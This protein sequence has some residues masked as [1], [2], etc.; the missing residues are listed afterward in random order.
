ML[1]NISPVSQSIYDILVLKTNHSKYGYA[2]QEWDPAFEIMNNFNLTY[3]VKDWQDNL[4]EGKDGV[5]NENLDPEKRLTTINEV[6]SLGRIV[7][8]DHLQASIL[9]LL[10][11]RAHIAING[12]NQNQFR[13]RESAFKD[14]EECSSKYLRAYYANDP[15]E[16]AKLAISLV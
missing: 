8:T 9:S 5:Y 11:G 4:P 1:G 10:T 14:K 16:A 7:I 6:I 3:V 13:T 2:K 12:K 15:Y